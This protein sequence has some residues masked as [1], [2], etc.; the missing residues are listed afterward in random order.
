MRNC[1]HL[2]PHADRWDNYKEC[3]VSA[4]SELGVAMHM[5]CALFIN[6]ASL[7]QQSVPQA[8][9]LLC[10]PGLWWPQ[11]GARLAASRFLLWAP[12]TPTSAAKKAKLVSPRTL[13][14]SFRSAV[15]KV[16]WELSLGE[17]LFRKHFTKLC[18]GPFPNMDVPLAG[19]QWIADQ[20]SCS[21]Q[22]CDN[23]RCY[24]PVSGT[25][26]KCCGDDSKQWFEAAITA[27]ACSSPVHSL[28]PA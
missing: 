13:T 15:T 12:S 6:M 24:N 16:S 9:Q 2:L 22:C 28:W 18:T 23:G 26:K 27:T 10:L 17:L 5:H 3:C 4:A 11:T 1:T 14:Q 21:G 8:D 19:L 25:S 7:H 20:S